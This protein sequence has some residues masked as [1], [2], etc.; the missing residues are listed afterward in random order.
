MTFGLFFARL[1]LCHKLGIFWVI[2]QPTTSLLFFYR[3]LRRLIKRHR[4]KR[5]GCSLGA[6]NANTTKPVAELQFSL[7][8][9][10]ETLNTLLWINVA[11]RSCILGF[12]VGNSAISGC[13]QHPTHCVEKASCFFPRSIVP[14]LLTRSSCHRHQ[15]KKIRNFLKL[16]TTR[17]YQDKS[18]R[19]RCARAP[20][21]DGHEI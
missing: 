10:Y 18:G 2:E 21:R 19:T 3:P 6:M 11:S 14:K 5:V 4:A 9:A 16:N 12:L 17:V 8:Q 7:S 20:N 15:L 1:E 13:L